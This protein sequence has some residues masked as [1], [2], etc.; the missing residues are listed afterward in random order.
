MC[1]SVKQPR[2]RSSNK[3]VLQHQTVYL[4]EVSTNMSRILRH[5]VSWHWTLKVDVKVWRQ[6]RYLHVF[7]I[8]SYLS[9]LLFSAICKTCILFSPWFLCLSLEYLM[10]VLNIHT[11][12]LLAR[13]AFDIINVTPFIKQLVDVNTEYICITKTSL[14]QSFQMWTTRNNHQASSTQCRL[15]FQFNAYVSVLYKQ[16]M[17]T[18]VYRW[19][20]HLFNTLNMCMQ[21]FITN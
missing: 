20:K 6:L 18:T 14:N 11:V 4:N 17:R 3:K 5:Y 15:L 21:S 10:V 1:S 16:T 12:P 8:N 9:L 2:T 19:T 7:N 13:F